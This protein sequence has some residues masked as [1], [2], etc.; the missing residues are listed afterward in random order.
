MDLDV[1]RLPENKDP[2]SQEKLKSSKDMWSGLVE[3]SA[4]GQVR[5]VPDDHG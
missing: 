2:A 1:I 4:T 5:W 3:R